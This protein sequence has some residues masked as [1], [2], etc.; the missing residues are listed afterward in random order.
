MQSAEAGRHAGKATPE[1]HQISTATQNHPE[2]NRRTCSE[3]RSPEH[4]EELV[5]W[6]FAECQ[7]TKVSD[8]RSLRTSDRSHEC[9][10]VWL[11]GG[12]CGELHQQ[13]GLSDAA[14]AGAAEAGSHFSSSREL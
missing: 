3:R 6:R 14:E 8:C 12:E 11:S 10:G 1:T 4:G 7:T 2:E 9:L 13:R 5:Q